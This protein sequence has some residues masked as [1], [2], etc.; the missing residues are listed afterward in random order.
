[1]AFSVFVEVLNL[2]FRKVTSPLKLHEP[3]E[4]PAPKPD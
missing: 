2:R 3:F 1:M 4:K